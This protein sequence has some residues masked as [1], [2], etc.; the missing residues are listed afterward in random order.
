M[1]RALEKGGTAVLAG[2][3]MSTTPPLD[4]RRCLYHE[5]ILT[6][7]A[8]ATRQD[9]RDLLALARELRLEM[10]TEQFP[11]SD[12]N[13]A[14]RMVKESLIEASAVLMI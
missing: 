4:Y 5:K 12:A 10:R 2:V 1:L 9:G 3:A 13:R 6:S 7:V 8:N 11:L 14:L